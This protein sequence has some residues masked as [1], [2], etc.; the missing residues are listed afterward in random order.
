M[1]LQRARRKVVKTKSTKDMIRYYGKLY[2]ATPAW[3]NRQQRRQMN[4]IYLTAK[5]TGKSV[6]HIVPLSNPLVCGLHVPWNLQVLPRDEN[7]AKSNHFWPDA[8][9]EQ[10]R[11]EL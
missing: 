11:L 2:L 1:W 6:D 4:K 9:F 8:P 7:M 3:L 10:T 5:V